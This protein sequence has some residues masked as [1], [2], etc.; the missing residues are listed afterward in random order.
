MTSL[1]KFHDQVAPIPFSEIKKTIEEDF[2]LKLEHIFESVDPNPLAAASIAQVHS[3]AKLKSGEDVVLK[4]FKDQVLL[5]P[6][7]MTFLS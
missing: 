4:K 7:R 6:Y 1:K 5:K 3:S 2:N